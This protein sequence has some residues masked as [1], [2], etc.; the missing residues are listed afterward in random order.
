MVDSFHT[1]DD[2][3]QLG[4][5]VM[6]VFDHLGLCIG[7][8]GNENRTGVCDRFG[9][10]VKIVVILRGVPAADGIR[11]VMD[12]PGRMIRVQN[13]S[14]DVCRAEMEH[15][16][17]MVINPNDGM[18]ATWPCA[19]CSVARIVRRA[20][21]A[22]CWITKARCHTRRRPGRLFISSERW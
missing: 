10:G 3:H 19:L 7:G 14:F 22:R 13:E 15:A 21:L 6:N 5:V 9:G 16:R 1:H 18:I 17:F 8:S 12:V 4:V 2:V 20:I 11:L